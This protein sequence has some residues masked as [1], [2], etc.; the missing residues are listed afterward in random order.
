MGR[1]GPRRGRGGEVEEEIVL[2]GDV[3]EGEGLHRGGQQSVGAVGDRRAE[4]LDR[5]RCGDRAGEANARR[6]GRD[7]GDW[8]RGL[9]GWVLK[10]AG[11][12]RVQHFQLS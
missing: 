3:D 1:I 2:G 5:R 8:G 4:T 7:V 11:R 10:I 9:G 12:G 6:A